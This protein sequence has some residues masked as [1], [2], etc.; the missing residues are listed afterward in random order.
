M[1]NEKVKLVIVAIIVLLAV[2]FVPWL[3]LFSFN[4]GIPPCIG[5]GCHRVG[6]GGGMEF[7]Y[8][9]C[10]GYPGYLE[11][12]YFGLICFPDAETYCRYVYPFASKEKCLCE[13][14][15][16]VELSAY[17]RF[18]PKNNLCYGNSFEYEFGCSEDLEKTCRETEKVF[19][20][21]NACIR[22]WDSAESYGLVHS[23]SQCLKSWSD[24]YIYGDDIQRKNIFNKELKDRCILFCMNCNSSVCRQGSVCEYAEF[25]PQ[26]Q[27]S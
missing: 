5:R 8:V 4:F 27:N 3:D 16:R 12:G 9:D 6:G 14:Y 7:G 17:R 15:K 21:P 24:I 11:F 10:R 26:E 19:T 2:Y 18:C 22:W 23:N 1:E 13:S 25:P 20:E